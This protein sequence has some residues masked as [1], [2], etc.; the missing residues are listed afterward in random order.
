MPHLPCSVQL[1]GNFTSLSCACASKMHAWVAVCAVWPRSTQ[2]HWTVLL[3]A[4]G[5]AGAGLALDGRP[6]TLLNCQKSSGCPCTWTGSFDAS[7][8]HF[9]AMSLVCSWSSTVWPM[10]EVCLQRF[11]FMPQGMPPTRNEEVIPTGTAHGLYMAVSSCTKV[12]GQA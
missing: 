8:Q 7:A 9:A 11:N 10:L 6:L 5:Q 4:G 12:A 1:D 2:L 3:L